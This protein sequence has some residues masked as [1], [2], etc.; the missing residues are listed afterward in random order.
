MSPAKT[1]L[2]VYNYVYPFIGLPLLLW[3][4]TRDENAA[5]AG[6][7]MGLPFVF[8][9][10]VPGIGTNILK[11]WRFR[12]HWVVGDYF[13]HHGFIYAAT[14]GLALYV[15]FVP[16]AG[17]GLWGLLGNMART[18]SI[19]GFVGWGHDL[20]AVRAGVI[21]IYNGPWKRGASPEAI[22]SHSTPLCYALLGAAYAGVATLGYDI[23]VAQQQSANNLWWLF[24]C[25][26]AVMT[27]V[28]S[29]PYLLM[30]PR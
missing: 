22:V 6:L 20:L 16:A 29:V 26:L 17:T 15:G 28:S 11:L 7:V 2:F 25:G 13:I 21:E 1:F 18:A 9:Y 4:W 3:L 8:G 27:L 24:P 5:F 14:M 23:L 12:G 30:E 10:L 19:I